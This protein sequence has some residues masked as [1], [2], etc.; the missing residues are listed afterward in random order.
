MFNTDI[1]IFNNLYLHL[2]NTYFLSTSSKIISII[3]TKIFVQLQSKIT[4][5]DNNICSTSAKILFIQQQHSF[6][7]NQN[8]FYSTKIFLQLQAKISSD[9]N[10]CSSSTKILFIQLQ[11]KKYFIQPTTFAQLQPKFF[12]FN[13]NIRST[14]TKI[15]Q[16][17]TCELNKKHG[18]YYTIFSCS[19]I[20]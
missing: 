11:P 17:H 18:L 15:I 13:N 2:N 14:S 10:I 3:L 5:F 16:Q 7:F 12:S 6:N 19:I 1:F 4:S 8:Y 20:V 9:K